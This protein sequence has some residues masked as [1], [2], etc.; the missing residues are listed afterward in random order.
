MT[1]NRCRAIVVAALV[2]TFGAA[3]PLGLDDARAGSC[4]SW[5]AKE[6]KLGRLTNGAR[7]RRDKPKLKLDPELS[8]VAKVHAKFMAATGT[9]QHTPPEILADRVTNWTRLGENVGYGPTVRKIHRAFM[10]STVH[11][12]KILARRFRHFGVGIRR[13]GDRL[14]VTVVFAGRED[15]G[16]T[17]P[18]PC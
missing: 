1:W 2:A 18:M 13:A 16:T 3:S 7:A 14:W 9:L 15:P 10:R 12:E 6:K 8:K 5:T 17:L 11:R 4:W